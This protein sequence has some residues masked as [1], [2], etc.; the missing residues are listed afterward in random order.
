[1]LEHVKT[2]FATKRRII[3]LILVPIVLIAAGVALGVLGAPSVA[4]MQNSFGEVDDDETDIETDIVI[5]N[6]NP[7]GVNVGSA[8]VNYSVAMNEVSMATGDLD[9]V[10][11]GSGNST[12]SLESTMRNAGI[13]EWWPRHIDRGEMTDVDVDL[14]ITTDRFDRSVDHRHTTSIETD[15]LSAFRSDETREVNADHTG[16]SDPVLYINETDAE[17]DDVTDDETPI[18]MAFLV[19]NP[20]TEPYAITRLGYEI[21]MNDITVGDGETEQEHVIEGH[22]HETIPLTTTI[23]ATALDDWWVT[24]LQEDVHGHQVSELRIEFYAIVELPT[25]ETIEVDL[26]QLTYEE[27]IGTDVFDEGGDVGQTPAEDEE[28]ADDTGEEDEAD[29]EE[30][31][32]STEDDDSVTDDD[33]ITDD[34]TDDSA[35][36]DDLDEPND[37]E[38][39]LDDDEDDGL[40]DDDDN[41]LL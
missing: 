14:T 40:I 33:V 31:D 25:G 9:G 30:G 38:D 37:D 29:D 26:E 34:D 17:W 23:D 5:H 16:V 32:D 15:I 13:T 11:I 6:P 21:S 3:G 12:I 8:T 19:Y 28:T 4:D 24:H 27:W 36:E 7:I 22:S 41:G 39:D 35:E 10:N 1:M 18:G 2:V 20:N